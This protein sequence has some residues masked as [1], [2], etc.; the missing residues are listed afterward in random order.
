MNKPR[1]MGEPLQR[2][3]IF[4]GGLKRAGAEKVVCDLA[5]GMQQR[6]L[7][8]TVC[9]VI[10]GDL[11]D[12]L[13][14]AGIDV[15]VWS[16][17]GRKYQASLSQSVIAILKT[18]I[19]LR[20]ERIQA[21][22]IHGLGPE[23]IALLASR[24]AGTPVRTFVFHSNYPSLYPEHGNTRL[25][26]RL[27]AD[28]KHV[29]HFIAISE[30]VMRLA[31]NSGIVSSEKI[32]VIINGIDL[33]RMRSSRSRPEVRTSLGLRD[34]DVILIQVGRF[35]PLKNQDISVRAVALLLKRIPRIHLLLVGNGPTMKK[36]KDLVSQLTIEEYVHFLGLRSDVR[37]ILHASDLFLLPSDWEGIPISLLE[38][39]ANSKPA[40]VTRVP[41]IK[42]IIEL[43]LGCAKMVAPKDEGSLA[44]AIENALLDSEWMERAGNA[45]LNLVKTNFDS[46]RMVDQY[47]SLHEA[48]FWSA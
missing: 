41:G 3:M 4:S 35:Q 43:D 30:N 5:L 9:S 28:F 6:G 20:K 40:V 26:K 8:V 29:Q 13:A 15:H 18:S 23:R 27:K 46:T 24:L 45:G 19:L 36:V 14:K 2:I 38:A 17:Q 12:E 39:F 22:N 16:S 11:A 44:L 31:V 47:V 34:E 25:V 42:D 32:S 10:G 33:E 37:D 21:I 1:K 7:K 48:L